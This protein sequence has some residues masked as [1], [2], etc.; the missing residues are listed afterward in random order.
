MCRVRATLFAAAIFV[1]ALTAVFAVER[2][3][4]E[5]Q[6]L[7]RRGLAG[8]K[9]A[10]ESCIGKLEAVVKREPGNQLARVYLGSAYTLRSRDLGFGPGKLQALRRGLSLMDQA[11]AAAPNDP[12]IRLARA[13]TTDAL[14][15]FFGR[16]KSTQDDF[17]WLARLLER[18]PEQFSEVDRATI[19]EHAH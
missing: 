6:E 7:Y 8:D 2:E 3:Q 4:S 11:V 5:I 13:R 16:R 19:E 9:A 17:E 18:N 14:P 1:I 15:A 10:V 12:Q